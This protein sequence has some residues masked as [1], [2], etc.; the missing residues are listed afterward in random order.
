VVTVLGR[1]GLASGVPRPTT[2]HQPA[3]TR[4]GDGRQPYDRDLGDGERHEIA[5]GGHVPLLA[6]TA[7]ARDRRG[8]RRHRLVAPAYD[9]DVLVA[10]AE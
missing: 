10:G 1:R 3:G 7:F 4:R 9:G 2:G 8:V 5:C 6:D